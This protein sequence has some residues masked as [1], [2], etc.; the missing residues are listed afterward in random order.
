MNT[1]RLFIAAALVLLS[2]PVWQGEGDSLQKI[3]YLPVL[4]QDFSD[5]DVRDAQNRPVST[6]DAVGELVVLFRDSAIQLALEATPPALQGLRTLIDEFS[7]LLKDAFYDCRRKAKKHFQEAISSS[8][9][10]V[11]H[12]VHNLWIT[13]PDGSWIGKGASTGFTLSRKP[14]TLYLRC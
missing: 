12:N 6:P 9:R 8:L 13:L 4:E 11:V 2:S 14:Q 5:L 10:Q 1:K 3:T 7:H